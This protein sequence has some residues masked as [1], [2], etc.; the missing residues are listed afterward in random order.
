[1]LS[2]K[3][4]F[5]MNFFQNFQS[6]LLIIILLFSFVNCQN[7]PNPRYQQTSSLIGKRLY[8]FGGDLSTT[9]YN[10]DQ[11][12]YIT[13]EVWY[14]DLSSSFNTA[15]PPWNKDI[16]MPIG[17]NL[18]TSCVSP[19]DNSVFLVG[20]LMYIPNTATINFDSS[21]VYVFNSNIS[22]WTTPNI[23][24]FNSSF[25]M[26]NGIQPVID[27][28]GK[29]YAYSGSN[30]TYSNASIEV[31]D[32]MSILDTTSMAWSTLTKSS[33][34]PP[35]L[36]SYTATLLPTGIIVYIG[37]Y[38]IT[39]AG[40]FGILKSVSMYEIYTF[41]TKN[42]T[43]STKVADG[44]SIG[45]RVG[46]SAV[47]TQNGDI[48]IYGGTIWNDTTTVATP[49]IAKLDTSSWMWSIPNLS[50]RDSPQLCFHSAAL[51]GDYMI[52][53]FGQ[54][55]SM[56]STSYSALSTNLY[57]L[58]IKSYT[59]VASFNPNQSTAN[60]SSPNK[61]STNQLNNGL[62]IGIGIGAGI[63]LMGVFSFVGFLLYKRQNQD[64][65]SIQTPGTTDQI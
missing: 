3:I 12:A 59:W 17:Y 34:T 21:P 14:L 33:N 37:G 65:K 28:Y 52:I 30:S 24:G 55:P 9:D 39:I 56:S 50:Q 11:A 27:N 40:S 19:I 54:I 5:T 48:V 25:K 38:K 57:I 6:I 43:W 46:H 31:Y 45:S 22:L 36:L 62:F 29:I 53:A 60:Q 8:F 47:L 61:S 7:I 10:N 49:Y 16:G 41:N 44:A 2:Y 51:Y 4:F 20:G 63:I 32:D 15:T 64:P 18:G 35:I 26:R 58:D 42:Y 13:N 23:I 1:M